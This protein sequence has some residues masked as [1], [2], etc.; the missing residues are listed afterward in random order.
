MP[1]ASLAQTA[2]ED[3]LIKGSGSAVYLLQNGQRYAFPFQEVYTL[4]YGYSFDRVQT[5]SDEYISTLPLGGN[6]IFPVGTL[7]KITTVPKVYEV[8]SGGVLEWVKTEADAEKLKGANW[9]KYVRDVPDAFWSNYSIKREIVD[10][11]RDRDGIVNAFDVFPDGNTTIENRLFVYEDYENSQRYEKEIPIPYD[12]YYYYKK[13]KSHTFTSN[14]SNLL[15]YTTPNDPVIMHI[16]D[17]IVDTETKYGSFNSIESIF[18]M[19]RET[20]YLDDIYTG[21]AEYPKYPVETLYDRTGDCEDSAFL[22]ASVLKAY[23]DMSGNYEFAKVALLKF[24]EHLAVGIG[25]NS[26]ANTVFVEGLTE[27]YGYFPYAWWEKDG[28]YYYYLETT[29]KD[30]LFGEMPAVYQ[31]ADTYIYDL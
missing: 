21:S 31:G 18:E 22:M 13:Y 10:I 7:V 23:F 17:M 24:P 8:K 6:V 15:S 19:L 16:A 2:D 29:S 26:E 12:R 3:V 28:Y 14:Y 20:L 30:Y 4:T 1:I 5:V 11:D 25:F 27:L 9:N